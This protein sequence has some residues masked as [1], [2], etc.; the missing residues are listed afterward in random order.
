M[1]RSLEEIKSKVENL[2]NVNF[3]AEP[4]SKKVTNA[5]YVFIESCRYYGYTYKEISNFLGLKN[6]SC[7]RHYSV[8][9]KKYKEDL[10]NIKKIIV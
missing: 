6:H 2:L 5:Y 3:N 10:I 8:Y 9:Y 4:R 1:K 7:S